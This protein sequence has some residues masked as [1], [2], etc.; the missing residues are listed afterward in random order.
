[1][2]WR[3]DAE[4]RQDHDVHFGVA[5]E[6]EQVLVEHRIAAARRVEEGRA[7]VAVGEQHGDRAGEHR[8]RQ[9]QQERGH[10][11][12]PGEQRHLVQRH[13]RRAHVE[14]RGD[15]VDRAED[16]G[17]AR[18]VQRQDAEIE[19]RARMARGR[20]RRIDR[21]AA[22]EAERA[23]RALD[24]EGAEQQAEAR[25]G[26]PERDVVHSRERHVGR[27]DHE[28]HEPVAEAA[29]E[30]RHHHE[31][32]HDEAVAGHEDVEGSAGSRR[33]AGPAPG[34]PGAWR[35]RGGRRR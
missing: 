22:A 3:H 29:D 26:E 6:P 11:H 33:T 5:E 13:A 21:P 32:H 14:D 9:E 35:W 18:K 34:A 20:E 24:E 31:E 4:G 8:Q 30:G 10:Q 7:E 15:E 1:M 19:R 16:R 25:D 23:R 27:A 28:R 12:R 17:R 2:M